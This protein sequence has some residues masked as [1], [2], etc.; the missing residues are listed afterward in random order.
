MVDTL[1]AEINEPAPVS[2]DPAVR[3]FFKKLLRF[4]FKP[5]GNLVDW[6]NS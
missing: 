2:I 3:D 5:P 4:Q 1:P 6:L